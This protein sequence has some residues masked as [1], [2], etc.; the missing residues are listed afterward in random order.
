[1]VVDDVE[2]VGGRLV[3]DRGVEKLSSEGG[4]RLLDRGIEQRIIPDTRPPTEA[5]YLIAM[6]PKKNPLG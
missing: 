3:M 6:D 1:M 2:E 5:L 4:S